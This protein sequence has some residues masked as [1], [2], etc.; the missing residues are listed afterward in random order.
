LP[1]EKSHVCGAD[2]RLR[3]R[4]DLDG[5]VKTIFKAYGVQCGQ[6]VRVAPAVGHLKSWDWVAGRLMEM[7]RGPQ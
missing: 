2:T 1:M 5:A 7:M 6:G 3:R 4:V